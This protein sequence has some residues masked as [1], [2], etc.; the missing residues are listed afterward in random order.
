M[1]KIS[2]KSITGKVLKTIQENNL[3]KKGD[4]IVVALSGGPDSVALIS[5]LFNLKDSIG[6]KLSACHFNHKLRG[7]SS[8]RDQKFVEKFCAE[9]GIDLLVGQAKNKNLYKNE[10]EARE[11]RYAYFE[12]ILKEGSGRKIAIAHNLNDLSETLLMRLIRGSGLRGLRSIPLARK[13][14]IRPLLYV[15]RKEIETYLKSGRI[16][17]CIDK[18][19]FNKKIFRNWVRLVLIP[20]LL[21]VNPNIVETLANSAMRLEE[22]YDYLFLQA[23]KNLAKISEEKSGNFIINYNSWLHLHPSLQAMILRS[24]IERVDS[25]VDITIKQTEEVMIML[26]SGVG[27][28]YTLLPRSLRIELERGKIIL[29]KINK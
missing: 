21:K 26:K 10:A 8:E 23:E 28:K 15:S 24:A 17:Y 3:V 2:Q 25:L 18:T 19:N 6:F 29:S 1:A 5:L 27:K 22:D 11:A 7:E 16:S 20:L 13:N 14:F 9:R 4:H 12:K